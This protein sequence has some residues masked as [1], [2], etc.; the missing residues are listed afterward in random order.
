MTYSLK[1]VV[2][3]CVVGRRVP[4]Q[5]ARDVRPYRRLLEVAEQENLSDDLVKLEV[6]PIVALLQ[7]THTVEN[8]IAACAHVAEP[9][10]SS[11]AAEALR[12]GE[13]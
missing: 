10:R 9:A 7:S 13:R 11:S 2:T 3:V 6:T 5:S 4:A 8:V 12:T 1:I